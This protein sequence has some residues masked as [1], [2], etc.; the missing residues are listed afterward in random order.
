MKHHN[1]LK[2][3]ILCLMGIFLLMSG[4]GQARAT[5]VIDMDRTGSLHLEIRYDGKPVT[6]GDMWIYQ[7]AEVVEDQ[8]YYFWLVPELQDA[9][10]SLENLEDS[11]LP[12][13][14]EAAVEK[15]GLQGTQKF[16]DENGVAEFKDL[17]LGLYLMVQ[18][19][20]SDGFEVLST[21]LVSVPMKGEDGY[22]YDV[23]ATPKPTVKKAEDKPDEPEPPK[24]PKPS[25]HDLPQ[26]GQLNWPVPIM[27]ASGVFFLLV[28]IW[29]LKGRKERT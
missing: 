16:F 3:A 14:L 13:K 12:G 7:V 26:T 28:G 8:G 5:E 29:L 1:R 9:G 27:G 6:G 11:A 17:P 19:K 25:D 21:I 2:R 10:I 15:A 24:P 18:K 23:D 4:M 20:P 22:V